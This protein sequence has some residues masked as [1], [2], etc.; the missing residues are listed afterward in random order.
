MKKINKKSLIKKTIVFSLLLFS[1]IVFFKVKAQTENNYSDQSDAIAVKVIPNPNHYSISTW[2][3]NQGFIGSPQSLTV[4]GYEAIRNGRTVYVN[5][6]NVSDD[7]IYTNIYVISFSQQPSEKTVDILGQIVSR[8]EFNDNLN[9]DLSEDLSDN[10]NTC[11]I[12]S[13]NCDTDE[14]CSEGQSCSTEGET[15]GTCLLEEEKNCLIDDDCPSGYFCNSP[16]AIVIRDTKR[17][18]ML[19]EMKTALSNY[20]KRNGNYPTF[21][22]GTYLADKSIS[23][24]PSWKEKVLPE[25]AMSPTYTDVIN[26]IGDCPGFDKDTCWNV[27]ERK[28]YSEPDYQS[29]ELELPE[30]SY[31]MVYTTN[32]EGSEYN[33]CSSLETSKIEKRFEPGDYSGSACQTNFTVSGQTGENKAPELVDF[34]LESQSDNELN[35]YIRVKDLNKDNLDWSLDT[36][37]SDWSGWI[38]PPRLIDTSSNYEKKIYAEKTAYNNGDPYKIKVT[39]TD[40]NGGQYEEEF[41]IQINEPGVYIEA[42]NSTHTLKVGVPF[43]YSLYFSGSTLPENIEDI[44]YGISKISDQNID[45]TNFIQL[46]A[47][48][49]EKVGINRYKV[50]Y[51]GDINPD[52]YQNDEFAED[53]RLGFEISVDDKNG[54][55]FKKEF[56]IDIISPKPPLD[57]SCPL[58]TRVN[59]EHTSDINEYSCKIGKKTYLGGEVEYSLSNTQAKLENFTFNDEGYNPNMVYLEGYPGSTGSVNTSIIAKTVFGATSTKIFNLKINSYCGDGYLGD[60]NTERKGGPYNDGYELCEGVLGITNSA[61]S[62]TI[63][64]QYA[65]TVNSD[66]EIPL[67]ISTNNYCTF[68]GYLSGGGYCGDYFCQS[69][70]EDTSNCPIDCSDDVGEENN[71]C[72]DSSDCELG[73]KCNTL[74]GSCVIDEDYC[75]SNDDCET[76]FECNSENECEAKCWNK[77]ETVATVNVFRGDATVPGE[78]T[79]K[80]SSWEFAYDFTYDS[81]QIND[82]FINVNQTNVCQWD[83]EKNNCTV[84]RIDNPYCYQPDPLVC[85]TGFNERELVETA[86]TKCW[87]DGFNDWPDQE[88]FECRK[89][90]LFERC[91]NEPCRTNTEINGYETSKDIDGLIDASG[92]CVYMDNQYCI[93]DSECND[94][95]ECTNHECVVKCWDAEEQTKTIQFTEGAAVKP[96]IDYPYFDQ[97]AGPDAPSNPTVSF[98]SQQISNSNS[99]KECSLDPVIDSTETIEDCTIVNLN[100]ALC[101]T[102]GGNEPECPEGYNNL[103]LLDEKSDNYYCWGEAENPSPDNSGIDWRQTKIYECT[104]TINEFCVGEDCTIDTISDGTINSNGEC[105]N[106]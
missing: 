102:S 4:D 91:Y 54:R 84:I 57:F 44:N 24:W 98:N 30:N 17:I 38:S 11:I 40:G 89:N 34:Y 43:K 49:P 12:S 63:N 42:E 82:T 97:T 22:A 80:P 39:V 64:M 75:G 67:E 21:S 20:Y 85:P 26:R 35:G 94:G 41:E 33:L 23:V 100:H 32:S 61:T 31:V 46:E 27:E 79:R 99:N 87:A 45:I 83:G 25:I 66:T 47:P 95:Y 86:Y 72:I 68:S 53:V 78:Y 76:G 70:Y 50:T 93:N 106:K 60:P 73:Y 37:M 5:A 7:K 105:V 51:E 9:E 92:N 16:K 29:L 18:G 58:V 10:P 52:D 3:S 103:T 71:Y 77:T 65:C 88:I 14:D 6:A 36:S 2:Y 1:F 55:E 101:E 19:E 48:R 28:F 56:Y 59:T 74:S 69:S 96:Y 13:Y 62:S 104:K 90:V 81:S 15:I 8:W